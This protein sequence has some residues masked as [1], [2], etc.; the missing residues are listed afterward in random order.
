MQTERIP[1]AVRAVP[2]PDAPIVAEVLRRLIA[3]Y[4]PQKV[5]L[6]GSA[7]RG[8]AGPDSDYDI[9]IVVPDAAP[10]ELQDERLGYQ[11]LV[12][13]SVAVDLLIYRASDFE[14]RLPLKASLPA[15]V[16]RE[17]RLLYAA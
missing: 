12:G 14:G 16:A 4:R 11:A 6:F 9:L 15:A 7:A 13:T 5:Y 10:L 3:A 1:A 8:D 17:G 2:H